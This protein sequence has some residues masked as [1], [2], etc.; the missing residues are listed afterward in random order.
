M[1]FHLPVFPCLILTSLDTIMVYFTVPRNGL[2]WSELVTA[3]LV[4][5]VLLCFMV[6]VFISA[7]PLQEVVDGMWPRLEW[8]SLY[9][10]VAL[11]GANVMP[12]NFYLHRYTLIKTFIIM[13]TYPPFAF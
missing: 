5:L 12:H 1:V 10:V 8:N 11:L 9:T 3:S 6:D 7:P 4:G 13:L 2:R